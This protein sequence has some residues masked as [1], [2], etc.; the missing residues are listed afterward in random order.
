MYV[1]QKNLPGM[2]KAYLIKYAE[3]GWLT[4]ML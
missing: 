2:G 4:I 1:N 3:I